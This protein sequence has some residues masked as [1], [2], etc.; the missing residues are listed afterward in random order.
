MRVIACVTKKSAVQAILRS[1]GDA[2]QAAAQRAPPEE[3]AAD[4]FA[5]GFE[6]DQSRGVIM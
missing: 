3:D 6:V 4:F 5:E 1:L 2:G